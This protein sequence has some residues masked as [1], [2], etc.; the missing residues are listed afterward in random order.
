MLELGALRRGLSEFALCTGKFRS[1]PIQVLDRGL[2][3]MIFGGAAQRGRLS[4]AEQRKELA[5][6]QPP[7]HNSLVQE[8]G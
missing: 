1:R 5:A 8:S 7:G 3:A 2:P 4:L 6:G